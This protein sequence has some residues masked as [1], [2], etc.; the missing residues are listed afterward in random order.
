MIES[1]T[2]KTGHS[3]GL[4]E[5]NVR[6]LSDIAAAVALISD[7]TGQ[8]DQATVAQATS[9]GEVRQNVENIDQATHQTTPVA[10][11]THDASENLTALTYALKVLMEQF[12]LL[13]AHWTPAPEPESQAASPDSGEVTLF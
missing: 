1:A 9:A 8:I 10:R 6:S 3:V 2:E 11:Q 5:T 13:D 12:L 4:V 7:M